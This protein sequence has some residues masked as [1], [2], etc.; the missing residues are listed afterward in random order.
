MRMRVRANLP[1]RSSYSPSGE[2]T[3]T[4]CV[5]NVGITLYSVLDSRRGAARGA[6]ETAPPPPPHSSLTSAR[7][8]SRRSMRGPLFLCAL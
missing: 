5:L 2:R 4:D 7:E 8:S 6:A 1:E 3:N